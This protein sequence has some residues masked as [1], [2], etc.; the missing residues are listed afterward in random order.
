[1]KIKSFHKKTLLIFSSWTAF[2]FLFALQSYAGNI[3]LGS[4][5]SFWILLAIW[6]ISGYAWMFLTPFVLFLSRK[7]PV[8]RGRIFRNLPVHI[9]AASI[10]AIV[11]L[12]VI[13]VFRQILLGNS[14]E[15]FT[16]GKTFQRL[17]LSNFN[18]DFLIYWILTGIGHLREKNRRYIERERETARLILETS[19]LETQLAQS[20][21]NT[22]R[23]Q[24]QPHFLFNTLNSISVLMY[25]DAAAAN[26][27]LVSLSELLRV[28]L[29]S[30]N[31][32]ETALRDELEFLKSYISI[33]QVRFEERLTV[34]FAIADDTL[35]AQVPSLILQPLIEN[36]IKHGIAPLAGAGKI[37][38]ESRRSGNFVELLVSDNGVGFQ[39][40][41]KKAG[42]TQI[43]LKNTRERLEKLYGKL[44]RFEIFS[45]AESG[46][47]VIIQIPY[48]ENER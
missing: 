11:H 42:G 47:K 9:A 35:D 6:L 32:Q 22:L 44:Q 4:P 38:V 8:E 25:D 7:F 12:S 26:K 33:E 29:K 16:F 28:A 23:Q 1:M 14:A 19:Q 20:Q 13:V 37:L 40:L 30:E 10:L 36:A 18:F 46:F 43:G 39:N 41:S 2:A 27:M 3:Y 34:D 17:F 48:H 24:L 15:T 31:V 5:S 21:L 45:D